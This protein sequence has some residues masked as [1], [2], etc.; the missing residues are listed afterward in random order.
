MSKEIHTVGSVPRL[1]D[2]AVQIIAPGRNKKAAGA[3]S[4]GFGQRLWQVV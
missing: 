4:S 2:A 1:R 3:R